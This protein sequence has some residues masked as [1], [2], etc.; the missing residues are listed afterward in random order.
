MLTR[1]SDR[2]ELLRAGDMIR[3]A[4]LAWLLSAATLYT[5][6]PKAL[7]ALNTMTGAEAMSF[8]LLLGLA[9]LCF[10]L[11]HA[12]AWFWQTERLERWALAAVFLWYA[13]T[14]LVSAFQLP[15]LIACGLIFA[16]L[17]VYAQRG[18]RA[19][20][21]VLKK[22]AKKSRGWLLTALFAAVFC[23]LTGYWLACRVL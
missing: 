22:P 4:L 20:E 17:L 7:R 18:A 1:R 6:L 15:L 12:A 23:G 16:L 10:L 3:R 5:A 21:P 8:P 19:D 13:V 2:R 9:A 14:A 11:L